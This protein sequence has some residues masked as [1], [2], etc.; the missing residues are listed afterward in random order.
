MNRS[1]GRATRLRKQL[2]V[3]VI[4]SQPRQVMIQAYVPAAAS[5]PACRMPPPSLRRTIRACAARSP[6]V[7]T[8]D[9]TGA[10]RP[11]ERQTDSVSNSAPYRVSGTPVATA[12]FQIRAPSQ[13]SVMPSSR[14]VD[15]CAQPL[16]RG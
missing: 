12:A 6:E 10:P 9:P 11:F 1:P 8:S 16:E 5:T 7:T 2:R 13:C 14:A 15:P 3:L 4:L